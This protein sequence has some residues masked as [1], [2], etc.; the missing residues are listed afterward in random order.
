M[1]NL[2]IVIYFGNSVTYKQYNIIYS[3]RSVS[4]RCKITVLP[5]IYKEH[6]HLVDL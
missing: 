5:L 6:S 3:G 1:N 4:W 2:L